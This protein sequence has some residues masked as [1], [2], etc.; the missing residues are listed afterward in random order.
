M[1][2]CKLLGSKAQERQGP[3]KTIFFI[4]KEFFSL[5][6]F[7]VVEKVSSSSFKMPGLWTP[8]TINLINQGPPWR[9]VCRYVAYVSHVSHVSNVTPQFIWGNEN[10]TPRRG[11]SYLE[12]LPTVLLFLNT[13]PFLHPHPPS[14][15][16]LILVNYLSPYF[17]FYPIKTKNCNNFVS[18]LVHL[19]YSNRGF[20]MKIRKN[21]MRAPNLWEWICFWQNMGM[22]ECFFR[23]LTFFYKKW[24]W[25][26]WFF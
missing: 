15:W 8:Y 21:D 23:K 17:R 19:W 4:E 12:Q 7:Y 16:R 20:F 5:S 2:K 24:A 22:R 11:I 3:K 18:F 1:K 14:L 25:E 13:R 9:R 6:S 10:R 26:K